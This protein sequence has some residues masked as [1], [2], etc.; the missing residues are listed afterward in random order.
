MYDIWK[1]RS[2]FEK[3]CKARE[4]AIE[5][6]RIKDIQSKITEL[7]KQKEELIDSIAKDIYKET[8]GS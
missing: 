6:P 5:D 8:Y 4:K 2:K 1:L 7:A 3:M